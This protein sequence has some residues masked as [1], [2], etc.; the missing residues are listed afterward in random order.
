M[1]KIFKPS[2]GVIKVNVF[3]EIIS[4]ANFDYDDLHVYYQLELPK[5]E[6]LSYLNYYNKI[7]INYNKK[8]GISIL[9]NLLVDL[10]KHPELKSKEMMKLHTFLIHFNLIY[11]IK[12]MIIQKIK[13]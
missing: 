1:R 3:G 2:I 11:I 10:H 12:M 7:K 5:S 13:V 4:A 6:H 8:I 9:Q